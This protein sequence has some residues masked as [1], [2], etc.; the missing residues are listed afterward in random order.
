MDSHPAPQPKPTPAQDSRDAD[1]RRLVDGCRRGERASQ[2]ELYERHADRV[3]AVILK[4]TGNRDEAFDL[5][6]DV[7]LRVFEKIDDFRGDSALSTWIHRVAVN[8]VLHHLRR[9]RRGRAA[10]DQIRERSSPY[11]DASDPD[12][13]LDLDAVLGDLSDDARAI[14]LLRYQQDL[15]YAE[16]ANILEISLGTVAS[17]LNRARGQLKERM[18]GCFADTPDNRPPDPPTDGVD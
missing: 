15:S 11:A 4:M 13:K 12:L 6:Q 16:I 10:T 8:T 7:F 5:S 3:Y 2:R 17:R 18:A 14:L 1:D 9:A